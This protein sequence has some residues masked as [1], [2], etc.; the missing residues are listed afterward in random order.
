MTKLHRVWGPPGTGKTNYLAEQAKR[1]ADK[2]GRDG[3]A[4]VS[5]TKAGAREI[6]DR[7]DLPDENVGTLHSFA[8][9]ALGR[10]KLADAPEGLK[11][12]NLRVESKAPQLRIRPGSGTDPD[13]APLEVTGGRDA[14]DG[15]RLLAEL[16][17][18]RAGMIPRDRWREPVRRFA[19]E[20]QAFKDEKGMVDFT[21]LIDRCGEPES[22]APAAPSDVDPFFA[23]DPSDAWSDTDALPGNPAVLMVD[24]AQDLS[25]LEMRLVEKWGRHCTQ[26]VIV[27]DPWQNLYEWRGSHPDAFTGPEAASERVLGQSYRVPA[28]A[29][30]YAVRWAVENLPD[31]RFPEYAPRVDDGRVVEGDPVRVID[32]TC[33]N[34]HGMIAAVERDLAEIE[35]TDHPT[36]MILASCGYM[37][38]RTQAALRERGIPFHNPYRPDHGAWNPLRGARAI[39]AFLAPQ[40]EDAGG[41]NRMWTWDDL[42]RWTDPLAAKGTLT[43]GAKALIESKCM[44][45]SFGEERGGDEVPLATVLELLDGD[46][47]REAALA[48]DLDWWRDRLR[49][50]EAPRFGYAAEIVRRRGGRALVDR[51]RVCVGTIHSVKG[52]QAESVYVIPD[53]SHTAYW[54]HWQDGINRGPTVRLFYVALT[55]TR[56]R[57]TV[58]SPAGGE[59]AHLPRPDGPA[60]AATPLTVT[61][62]GTRTRARLRDQLAAATAARAAEDT[63]P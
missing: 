16:G 33:Q 56:R 8:F 6:G 3:V 11:E 4:I 45:G 35:E 20:W 51:P 13:G 41:L 58:L 52:G 15:E 27:G 63:T 2:Y 22:T 57:L 55:R 10:P 36:V 30:A 12:W 48:G 1:A 37:L 38:T 23:D 42:R 32:A 14:S 7:A 18:L 54:G 9:R 47:A 24:E 49:A 17:T 62:Q 60:G 31:E 40:P 59:Y 25:A 39:R 46:E 61:T 29:Q 28:L 21:D 5:L 34:P 44:P 19:D 43:R 50:R 26:V 53:L